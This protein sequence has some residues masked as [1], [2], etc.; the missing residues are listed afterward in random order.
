[1][2]A[3]GLS[4]REIKGHLDA[5]YRVDVGPDFISQI[6]VVDILHE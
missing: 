1:M 3:C 2:Y 4:V 5:L 6:T